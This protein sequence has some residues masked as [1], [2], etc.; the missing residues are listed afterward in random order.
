MAPVGSGWNRHSWRAPAAAAPARATASRAAAARSRP[1]RRAIG[2][3]S[4]S[5]PRNGGPRSLLPRLVDGGR[6]PPAQVGP[7]RRQVRAKGGGELEVGRSSLAHASTLHRLL[8]GLP[9]SVKPP[10]GG[11]DGHAQRPRDLGHRALLDVVEGQDEPLVLA[12]PVEGPADGIRFVDSLEVRCRDVDGKGFG[13]RLGHGRHA[14]GPDLDLAEPDPV[15]PGHLRG[16]GHDAVEPA[17]ERARIPQARELSP[18][19]Q[20]RLLCGIGG[21]GVVEEDRPGEPVAAIETTRHERVERSASPRCARS[22]ERLV[23][24]ARY[25]CSRCRDIHR[26]PRSKPAIQCGVRCPDAGQDAGV[27]SWCDAMQSLASVSAK[28]RH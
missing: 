27:G 12:Q 11:A 8:E 17:V 6:D 15:A 22:D 20:E 23:G 21:I 14:E 26:R 3:A 7:R 19:R 5:V 16:I 2:S 1:R 4:V 9:G 28:A 25:A 18:G 13:I 24:R 10:L